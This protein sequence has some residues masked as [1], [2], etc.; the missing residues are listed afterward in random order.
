MSFCVRT[1]SIIHLETSVLGD[2]L[3]TLN[4]VEAAC[5]KFKYKCTENSWHSL[6]F[7]HSRN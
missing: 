3:N 1:F 5:F 6:V 4:V 7:L 2:I